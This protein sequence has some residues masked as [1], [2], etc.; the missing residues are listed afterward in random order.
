MSVSRQKA[1]VTNFVRLR[2]RTFIQN[3]TLRV[4]I[5]I[6]GKLAEDFLHWENESNDWQV[7]ILIQG[8]RPL[9]FASSTQLQEQ[10]NCHGKRERERRERSPEKGARA[11]QRAGEL[12]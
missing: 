7:S 3:I 5:P 10:G 11:L 12:C 9:E 2:E 1:S 8:A 4:Q 6:L